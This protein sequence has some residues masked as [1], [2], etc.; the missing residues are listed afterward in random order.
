M[1]RFNHAGTPAAVQHVCTGAVCRWATVLLPLVLDVFSP[2]NG[3]EKGLGRGPSNAL[4]SLVFKQASRQLEC[5]GRRARG[6]GSLGL[7]G[8]RN[9]KQIS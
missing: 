1:S 3:L 4:A 2:V 8:T 6:R 5:M 7:C 9:C